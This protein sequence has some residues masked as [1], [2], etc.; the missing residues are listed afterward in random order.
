MT[1]PSVVYVCVYYDS[2]QCSVCVCTMTVPSV[3][4]V[5]VYYDSAQCSVC[6]C[7]L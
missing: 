5:C 4:Y 2:A 7:V 3:V 6:V 1:V